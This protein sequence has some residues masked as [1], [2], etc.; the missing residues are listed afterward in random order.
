MSVRG[1]A[2]EYCG[3]P[4]VHEDHVV[5]VFRWAKNPRLPEA[6]GFGCDDPENK[7]PACSTCN[8]RRLTLKLLP[9]SWE[10]MVDVLNDV[11]P[12]RVPWRVWTTAPVLPEAVYA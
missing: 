12:S 3:A 6:L 11:L 1:Q 7:V 9:P 5:H 2:C 4:A 10:H 8:W